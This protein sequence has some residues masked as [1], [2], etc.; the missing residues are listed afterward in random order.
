M[1]ESVEYP[2]I[3]AFVRGYLHEDTVAEHGSARA[4]ALQFY[5][6]ADQG[7]VHELLQEWRQFRRRYPHLNDIN[8]SLH[9]LGC[10]WRFHTMGEFQQ[11]LDATRGPMSPA[12]GEE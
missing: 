9:Q 11:M 8:R 3:R 7:Q 4:A 6:D 12:G 1:D 5:R 2:A 10:A